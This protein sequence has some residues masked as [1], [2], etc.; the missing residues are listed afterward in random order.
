MHRIEL[1]AVGSDG[2][3]R[4]AS[5]SD[6][7][8]PEFWLKAIEAI[9]PTSRPT[10]IQR[11]VLGDMQVLENRRNLIVSAPTNSG[12]SLLGFLLLLDSVRIGKRALLI[13]PYRAIAQEKFDELGRLEPALSAFAGKKVSIK[14]STGDYRLEDELMQ[15]PPPDSGEIL[16]A[17]PERSEAIMRRS[18]YAEWWRS[19]G[20]VCAD[21]AQLISNPRRGPTLE[22]LITS[23]LLADQPPRIILLSAT[24]GEATRAL[25]W[26]EPCDLA[27]STVRQPLL[28]RTII[29]L[30]EEETA[31]EAVLQIVSDLA[32]VAAANLLVF[33]YR[34]DSA[35]KLARL[36]NERL[37]G[38]FG[39]D[40]ALAYHAKMPKAARDKVRDSSL[41]GRSRCVV[42]TTALAAGVNLPTTDVIVRDLTFQGIDPL[43][44][45]QLVQ[46]A[47]R[48]GRGENC[49]HVFFIHRKNDAWEIDKL[50]DQ[51]KEPPFP[52]L[53]SA[54]LGTRQQFDPQDRERHIPRAASV[55]LSLLARTDTAMSEVQIEQFF[56]RSLVGDAFAGMLGEVIDWMC[57][58]RRILAYRTKEKAV[59]PTSLGRAASRSTLPLVI[60]SGV[61]SLVRDVLSLG[62]ETVFFG[63][64]SELD[65]L[66]ILELLAERTIN[67]RPFSEKLVRQIDDWME[68][69]STKSVLYTRLIRGSLSFSKAEELFGS[70]LIDNTGL[71]DSCEHARRKAYQAMFRA[72]VL[73]E[74]GNGAQR[75]AM[76][77]MWKMSNLL[78]IEEQWRDD[79]IWL[80]SAFAEICDVH[81]FYYHLKEEC[82]ADEH[83]IRGTGRYLRRLRLLAFSVVGYLKHCSPLG[84]LLVQMRSSHSNRLGVG[85]KTVQKLETLGLD[86]LLA[87][88]KITA[89]ELE[90]IGISQKIAARIRAY[91]RRRAI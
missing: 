80:L 70:L 91:L 29:T 46:M 10:D 37:P 32:P 18:E 79:R 26:L 33:T 72:I 60:A 1:G 16:V 57:D 84:R 90:A 58:S 63:G 44:V 62:E 9:A 49:G 21:E 83:R 75:E 17:T 47:G 81:C 77:G 53:S 5:W 73:W 39:V 51:L 8:L 45:D 82:A 35:V 71:V 3:L 59:A 20:A 85:L 64:W 67:L 48:A 66:L 27:H 15:A 52:E 34:T 41:S 76:E 6:L 25:Q 22:F 12:K 31:D 11:K 38:Q 54:L 13:E 50:V 23:L 65:H 7:K 89:E 86:S 24:V 36:L 42:T 68:R 4:R 56:K 87:L 19:F 69:S 30:N 40:G 14:I 55:I 28:D 43:P 2:A 88:S 78:G 74:R 61:G